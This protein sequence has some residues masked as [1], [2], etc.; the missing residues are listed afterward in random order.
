MEIYE[1]VID[2]EKVENG[3]E[4]I[5]VVEDPAIESDFIAL[6]KDKKFIELK[7]IN[8]E[9]RIIMGAALIPNKMIYRKDGD[10]EYNIFFSK[11]TVRKAS[12]LF[13]K[14]GNQNKATLEHDMGLDG[15]SVVESWIK[16]DDAHDKSV[17]YG[18]DVPVGTWLI[19]MKVYNDSVWQDF[20]QSRKV[21]GFSI[22]GYFADKVEA[23]KFD[24][25][26]FQKEAD[27]ELEDELLSKVT[28]I[29]KDD[30]RT[31]EGRTLELRSYSDYPDSVKN[32]ARR[33]I[34]L[35]EKVNNQCATR[36]G[37]LRAQQLADSEPI[38]VKTIKRMASYLS[39]A[40][41]YYKPEDI[42]ACGTIS[43]LLW[44]G[45]SGLKWAESKLKEIENEKKNTK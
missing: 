38:S 42:E 37:K 3:I 11:S 26:E 7:E 40:E 1:L 28:A 6:S 43:Y 15:M 24:P 22:E 34:K 5:S 33:G 10:R 21:R 9:K 18:L 44:G 12:E 30:K 16:E 27:K 32:N 35:N 4:A 2:E 31:K 8:K 23:S 45:K 41:E 36:V 19:S 29:I 25:Q 39:R 20:I 13:F 17:K 14:R